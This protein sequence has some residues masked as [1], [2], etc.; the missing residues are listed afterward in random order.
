MRGNFKLSTRGARF[1]PGGRHAPG[2]P[3]MHN[4]IYLNIISQLRHHS[5]VFVIIVYSLDDVESREK[6]YSSYFRPNMHN[7]CGY[8]VSLRKTIIEHLIIIMVIQMI[9]QHGYKHYLC[10][11]YYC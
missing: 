6:S 8:S 10:S 4:M 2:H 1:T 7:L 11:Y 3:T 9:I 5:I